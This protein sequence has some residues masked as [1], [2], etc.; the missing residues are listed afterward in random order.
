MD[1]KKCFKNVDQQKFKIVF[2]TTVVV[3]AESVI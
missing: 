3:K 1:S 2:C